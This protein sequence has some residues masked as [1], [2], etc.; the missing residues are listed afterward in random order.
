MSPNQ[1]ET[2]VCG[3]DNQDFCPPHP[4]L[5]LRTFN[6]HSTQRTDNRGKVPTRM[7]AAVNMCMY[8]L[9]LYISGVTA[10]HP[11]LPWLLSKIRALPLETKT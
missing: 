6:D 9:G 4:C 1:G 8:I 10:S 11:H 3:G 2:A 7:K 5:W